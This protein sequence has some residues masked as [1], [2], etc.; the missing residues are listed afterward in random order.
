M[1]LSDREKYDI[2]AARDTAYSGRFYMAVTSTGIFCRPGCPARLPKRE[3]CVFYRGAEDAVK[4]GFRPCKRCHPM[5]MPGEASRLIKQL[6]N[7]VESDP[8]RKWT[9]TEISALGIDPSTARRHFKARFG[10][11]FKAYVRQRNLALARQSLAKGDSVINAQLSAGFES[12]SGFRQAFSKTFG[13]SPNMADKDP[14]LIS[15]LDT[16]L[17]PMMTIC[18]D[19]HVYLAEFTIRKNL[20]GQIDKLSK[21]YKRPILPGKSPV[22]ETAEAQLIDYFKGRLKGFELPLIPTGT[23]FQ[24]LVWNALQTIP[25]GH[26]WSYTQLAQAI[27]NEQAVRAVASSNARNG[28]AIIIPCHRVIS[29]GGGLGGYAG[30]LENKQWLLDHERRFSA[31]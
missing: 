15:W 7:L 1:Q 4:A 21:Y 26:T 3:N 29:K 13:A 17:G 2:F 9:E 22:T 10:M 30:G 5:H 31:S 16:P 18:D 24:N 27:G 20:M 6:I 12:P 14:L 8:E 25:Y 11:T 23:E 28:L 19:H